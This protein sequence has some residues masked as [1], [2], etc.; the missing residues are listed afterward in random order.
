MPASIRSTMATIV[1]STVG[2]ASVP[3]VRIASAG[4][5]NGPWGAV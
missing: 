4:A 3:A 1:S 2:C 5:W